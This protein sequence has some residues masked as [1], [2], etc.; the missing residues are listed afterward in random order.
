MK[1]F[2]MMALITLST[3]AAFANGDMYKTTFQCG[4]AV[5]HPDLGMSLQ[6]QEGGLSGIPRIEVTRFFL[7]HRQVDSYMAPRT[8]ETGRMGAPV[9]YQG[10]GLRFQI[11]MTTAPSQDGT[12]V[13]YLT[14][15][16]YGQ[17]TLK[18]KVTR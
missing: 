5:L 11:N 3:T 1:K 9:V 16:Q 10:Q 18:C 7:G 15:K 4:P 2:L 12:R 6:V 14:T 13:A 17:E 8:V